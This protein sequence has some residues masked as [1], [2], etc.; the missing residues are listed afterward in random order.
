[1]GHGFTSVAPRPPQTCPSRPRATWFLT[2]CGLLVLL[3]GSLEAANDVPV[4]IDAH[5][6]G[7]NI[8]V[9]RIEGSTVYLRPDLRDTEGWWFY[10]SFR[11]RG[12]QGRTLTFQFTG[13]NPIGVRGPAVSTDGGRTWAWLGVEAVQGASFKYTFAADAREVHFC[14]AVPYLEQNLRDF[15]ARYKGNPHIAVQELCKTKKERSVRG[16]PDN[17]EMHLTRSATVGRRGPRR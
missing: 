9:E 2:A 15:L 7:G 16:A 13:D 14:F 4:V 12:G 11:V 10:W 5:Y 1:M 3:I 17:N 6:S 8:I